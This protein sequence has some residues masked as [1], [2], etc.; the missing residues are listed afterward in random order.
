MK[1]GIYWGLSGVV[2]LMCNYAGAYTS[3]IEG[4]NQEI[5]TDSWTLSTNLYVGYSSSDNSMV[6]SNGGTV[7]SQEFG[8]IGHLSTA[9]HNSVILTGS[10]SS[11]TCN[12]LRL[13]YSGAYNSVQVL[14]GAKFFGSSGYYSSLGGRVGSNYNSL[15][16][17]GAGSEW[18][19][20]LIIMADG[21]YNDIHVSNGGKIISSWSL[22]LGARSGASYNEVTV[23]GSGS[24]IDIDDDICMG[25]DWW[26]WWDGN[27]N[28]QAIGSKLILK[29]GAACSAGGEIVNWN[30][31]T[32]EIGMQCVLS[33]QTYVQN[34][35]SDLI[36]KCSANVAES[37]KLAL[38]GAV[39]LSGNLIVTCDDIASLGSGYSVDLIDGN[40][41]GT[42]SSITLPAIPF[43]LAWDTSL[44]YSDGI[45]S[46]PGMLDTD[47]DGISDSWEIQ[48]FGNITSC[49]PEADPDGDH[50][51][52]YSEYIAGTLPK[53]QASCLKISMLLGN[54]D[55]LLNWNPVEDRIYSIEWTPNILY[56]PFTP[57]KS[58]MLYPQNSH[59][60]TSINTS[61]IGYYRM[62]VR[63]K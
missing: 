9:D 2:V 57:I 55:C 60:D 28:S 46:I 58:G 11:W 47:D 56:T 31:S 41:S 5:V 4:G 61:E 40:I 34:N 39:A 6:V 54:G 49:D 23:E 16:V 19:A 48:Y 13:G 26:E 63:I 32:V 18:R 27:T 21:Q 45:I 42:F 37:G 38:Q 25:I 30:Q 51:D 50:A 35:S 14:D 33:A 1:R 52:N 3:P 8:E 17:D 20:H 62:G 36:I 53:D 15:L 29:E 44:L 24:M 12:G 10:G 7:V 43:H 59:T 22:V